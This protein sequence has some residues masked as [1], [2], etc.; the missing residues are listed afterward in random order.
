MQTKI[1]SRCKIDK[2]YSAYFKDNRR[3][4][5]IRCRCKECC[6]LETQEWREKN[7]SDYNS[8]V[9][10]WRGENPERQHATEIKRRYGLS[11]ERYNEMLAEQKLQCAICGGQHDPS[12]K[13]GRLYVDHDHKTGE[14]RALLCK[15]CN[16][17]IGYFE[18]NPDAML[19][20]IDYLKNHNPVG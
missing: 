19:K 14:V 16:S 3:A 17:A 2:P 7:R 8:Y 10:M 1:C 11:I 9:S 4:I 6:A 20:A 18:E 15:K 13:R 5:G 12:K